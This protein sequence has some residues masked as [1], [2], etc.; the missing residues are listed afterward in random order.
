MT[1]RPKRP[2][3]QVRDAIR[4]KHYETFGERNLAEVTDMK[5]SKLLTTLSDKEV[6]GYAVLSLS[7][8]V[9]VDINGLAHDSRQ[10]RPG[11]LF[12]AVKGLDADGH[13]FIPHAIR[14]GAVAVVGDRRHGRRPAQ[15]RSGPLVAHSHQDAE[16][17]GHHPA[18]ALPGAQLEPLSVAPSEG[19]DN[20]RGLGLGLGTDQ[21][22]EKAG[23]V[24]CLPLSDLDTFSAWPELGLRG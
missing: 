14:Q 18:A 9:D 16:H 8:G 19:R 2:L 20:C 24:L 5:L 23:G 13:D 15:G 6:H 7:K 10:V 4:L 22:T 3:D 17:P 11:D 1:Q 21:F 12:V